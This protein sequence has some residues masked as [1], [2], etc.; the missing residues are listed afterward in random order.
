MR[1]KIDELISSEHDV[2]AR[3]QQA[4]DNY[5]SERQEKQQLEDM[6]IQVKTEYAEKM[7]ANAIELNKLKTG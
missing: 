3:Y 2:K 4:V 1:L 7:H 6:L 5:E